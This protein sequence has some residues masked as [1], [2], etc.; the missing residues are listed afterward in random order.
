MEM[1]HDDWHTVYGPKVSGTWNLHKALSGVDLDFFILSSSLSAVFGQYGQASYASAN[2]F[3]NSFVQFRHSQGLPCSVIDIGAMSGVGA[4]HRGQQEKQFSNLGMVLLHEQA[5][6]DAVQLSIIRSK[7]PSPVAASRSH[8]AYTSIGEFAIGMESSR[9]MDDPGNRHPIRIDIRMGLAWQLA[10]SSGTTTATKNDGIRLLLAQIESDPETLNEQSILEKVTL[11]IGRALCGFMLVPETNLDIN[12]TLDSMG[13]DSLVGIE[14]R[15]W[16]KGTLGVDI[17]VLEITNAGT[18]ARLGQL[19]VS[20]LKKKHE[21]HSDKDQGDNQPQNDLSAQFATQVR[22]LSE[23]TDSLPDC[24]KILPEQATVL[25]TGATGFLG[26]EI[27]RQ[28]LR[29]EGVGTVVVL[30]RAESVE[31]GMD[32]IKETAKTA[33]W[34]TSKDEARVE[35]W[36][37]DLSKPNVGLEAENLLRV[38]GAAADQANIDA[39]VH[40]G[41]VVRLSADYEALRVTNVQATVDL[42]ALALSS[43]ASPRFVFVSGGLK[44]DI[45]EPF[46][47]VA[48]ELSTQLGYSQTKNMSERITLAMAAQMPAGQNR[49]SV[50]KPGL[51]VGTVDNGFTNTNDLIWHAIAV[52]GALRSCPD[53]SDED[54]WLYVCSVDDITTRIIDQLFAT[55]SKS[56]FV[57]ITDGMMLSTFWNETADELGLTSETQSWDA[58]IETASK[59]MA[60]PNTIATLDEVHTFNVKDMPIQ[61]P[62]KAHDLLRTRKALRSSIRYLQGTGFIESPQPKPVEIVESRVNGVK[63]VI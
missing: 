31:R 61:Q 45:E 40:N 24:P 50:V 32:R 43:P 13:V 41:A 58:W 20:S 25:L 21:I 2:S 8:P 26:I 62:L 39:I 47:A 57:D 17:S 44:M 11:E 28:L 42:L 38:R 22:R 46:E 52:V 54:R 10:R 51:I 1:T 60:D 56:D 59:Q 14:I 30:V 63:E 37:G 18:I 16:W 4:V 19:A 55:E 34:W 48:Q 29:H 7:P 12:M 5:L 9:P 3:L 15:N 6:I 33:G 36:L 27:L 49:I 23:Y 53:M 35:I